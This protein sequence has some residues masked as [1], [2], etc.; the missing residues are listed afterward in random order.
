MVVV[1]GVNIAAASSHAPPAAVYAPG[2]IIEFEAPIH[3]PKVMLVEGGSGRVTRVGLR[4][5][6]GTPSAI[7]RRPRS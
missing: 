7:R 5:D 3:V 2:G 4:Q 6:I 1:S